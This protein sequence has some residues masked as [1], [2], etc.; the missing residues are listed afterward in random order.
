M[1]TAT[2]L[3]TNPQ[4]QQKPQQK[5]DANYVFYELTRSICPSAARSSTRKFCSATTRSTCASAAPIVVP[6]R[7]S[8]TATRRP[9]QPSES[10]TSQGPFRSP[11][12][13]K[14]LK[15]VR[16]TAAFAPITSSMP[17]SVSSRSTAPAIWPVPCASQT[18]A[19]GSSLT[20]EEVEQMLD[21]FVA[22][23]GQSGG[24]PVFRWRA[25]H[26]S[27]DSRLRQGRSSARHTVRD[28]QHQRQAHRPR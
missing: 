7:G 27:A 8:S 21:H 26:P 4:S 13:P 12:Q 6:S 17:A 11:T 14:L 9:I 1:E 5:K 10:T 20:M 3:D 23:E 24:R 2:R 15:G 25:N 19:R 18:P 16:T 28:D 22:T